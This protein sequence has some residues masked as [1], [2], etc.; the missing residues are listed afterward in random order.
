MAAPERPVV[1][2]FDVELT[3]V[4]LNGA[5]AGALTGFLTA[6]LAASGLYDVVPREQVKARLATQKAAS[7]S[8]CYDEACQLEIGKELAAEK[9]LAT[10]I[11]KLGD[12][13]IA[14]LTLYDLRRATT[15][16]AV[17]ARGGCKEAE[18]ARTL[19]AAVADLV[20]RAKPAAPQPPPAAAPVAPTVAIA[21]GLLGVGVDYHLYTRAPG[22]AAWSGP[23]PNSCCVESIALGP[24]G[25]LVGVG[26]DHQLWQKATRDIASAWQGPLPN[27]C[28]VRSIALAPDETLVGVGMNHT[29]WRKQTKDP[30]SAWEGPIPNSCCVRSIAFDPKGVLLGVG[31]LND[32]YKKESVARDSAWKGPLAGSCCVRSTWLDIDGALLGVSTQFELWKKPG[33]DPSAPW[34]GPIPASGSVLEVIDLPPP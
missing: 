17:T 11:L 32:V 33:G 18:L 15:D 7:K 16:R 19:E 29:L 3:R 24:D 31:M 25:R 26:W 6:R 27:S 5:A 23:V 1:A 14:T 34:S 4:S 28:C 9:S 10:G 8:A 21:G 22:A 2:V 12:E 30:T 13:C 20:A